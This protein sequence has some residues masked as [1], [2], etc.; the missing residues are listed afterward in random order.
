MS[1]GVALSVAFVA[2]PGQLSAG[3]RPPCTSAAG[4]PHLRIR[5]DVG[6]ITVELFEGAAPRS[7]G[8]LS[9]SIREGR[10]YSG[11]TF[12]YTRPHQEIRL[13]TASDAGTGSTSI[14]TQLDAVALGL[15]RDR[16]KSRGEAMNVLQRELL[17]AFAKNGK[18]VETGSLLASWLGTWY[19]TRDPGFLVGASRQTI[20]EALGYRYESGLDSR[21]P[22][23]G[24]VAL[25][26]ASPTRSTPNLSFLLSDMASRNGR[27]MVVG[28]VTQGLDIV[29]A[30]SLRPRAAGMRGYKGF[31]PAAPVA[32]A[33]MDLRCRAAV[34]PREGVRR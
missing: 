24:T 1:L 10:L 33:S 15:D 17:E 13:R 28:R 12:G 21:R 14:P 23:R 11:A 26:P 4:R 31:E 27:W 7:L 3:G 9:D 22:V 16:V 20:N 29:E 25:E 8:E 30:I 2:A 32:V 34:P 19:R 5:T 6:A 18:R